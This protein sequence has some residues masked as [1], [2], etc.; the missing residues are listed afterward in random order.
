MCTA[1]PSRWRRA[2]TSIAVLC[3]AATVAA[4]A[5][6]PADAQTRPSNALFVEN[7]P[8]PTNGQRL[9]ITVSSAEGYDKDASPHGGELGGVGLLGPAGQSIL[10][11]TAASYAWIGH[12]L[13][14][15]A[16]G[17]STERYYQSLNDVLHS[18]T[19]D[20]SDAAAAGLLF[21]TPET[22]FVANQTANYASS[23]LYN[24]LPGTATI[25]PGTGPAA[26]AD[27]GLSNSQIYAY[28]SATEYTRRVST[29]NSV[30]AAAEWEHSDIV[31]GRADSQQ[32]NVYKARAG[33][34]H[35]VGHNFT[36]LAGYVYRFGDVAAGRLVPYGQVLKENELELGVDYHRPLSATRSFNVQIR[37]G[38]STIKLP[39]VT[40]IDLV[41]T[42][43]RRYEQFS[44][45]LATAYD[46]GRSWQ[47]SGSFR[48]GLEYV[49]GLGEPVLA[50]AFTAR[51]DG[52]LTRR[53]DLLASAAYSSGESALTRAA[54]L[55]NTY[56]GTVRLRFGLTRTW[57][58]YAE[59]LYYFYD[60]RGTAPLVPGLPPSLERNGVRVGL[61]L[62]VPAAG[63]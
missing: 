58:T 42:G 39:P 55:F 21:H 24:F 53:V 44:G 27:Y 6:S 50:D 37:L 35:H 26:T 20:A 17:G 29:R 22:T 9:D 16:S 59:Y 15:R 32:L 61:M 23:L 8:D 36:A 41:P 11:T 7:R 14:F 25:T 10:V 51:V 52:L 48:R 54:S 45:Q 57:A 28:S 12:Q 4:V 13:Q 46:F 19:N 38:G 56:T 62:R 63:K 43:D 47:A 30:S 31:G 5:P 60:S 1:L 34:A 18:S 3:T 49:T 40:G 33:F 2:A